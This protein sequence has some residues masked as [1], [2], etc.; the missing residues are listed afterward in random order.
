MAIG[1]VWPVRKKM[2]QLL[3]EKISD[4]ASKK[5]AAHEC[6]PLRH[7]LQFSAGELFQLVS[8]FGLMGC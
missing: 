5:D 4:A 1:E 8:I 7:R 2:S 6:G 3:F